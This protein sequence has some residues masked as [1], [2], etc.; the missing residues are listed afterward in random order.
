[1]PTSGT[2]QSRRP[3]TS[4]LAPSPVVLSSVQSAIDNL[5]ILLPPARD[6]RGLFPKQLTGANSL[7]QP[8]GERNK[9]NAT[10]NVRFRRTIY[11]KYFV[12]PP[13]QSGCRVSRSARRLAAP[14][15][16]FKRGVTTASGTGRS[17]LK[18][19]PIKPVIIVRHRPSVRW[20]RLGI[21]WRKAESV[22]AAGFSTRHHCFL[23]P[24]DIGRAIRRSRHVR[25]EKTI[26][27]MLQ[28]V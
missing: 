14:S 26:M 22:A 6:P 18:P 27:H 15:S 3:T 2:I 7:L 12:R 21:L 24:E 11:S 9:T 25:N 1:M 4:C 5:L 13:V 20:A 16:R 28:T 19:T 10:A 23:A 8:K 17:R